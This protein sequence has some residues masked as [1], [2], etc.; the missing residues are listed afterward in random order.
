MSDKRYI[1]ISEFG[2]IHTHKG[3]IPP[4][5]LAAA[6]DGIYNVID[7]TDPD[8]PLLYLGESWDDVDALPVSEP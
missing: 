4:E 8:G 3:E 5:I 1:T 2:D 6:D 7:I